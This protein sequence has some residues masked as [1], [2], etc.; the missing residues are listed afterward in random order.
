MAFGGRGAPVPLRVGH[1]PRASTAIAGVHEALR[2]HPGRAVPGSGRRWPSPT[3]GAARSG[4]PAT[5]CRRSA[6]TATRGLGWAG[7][8]VGDGV[9]TTN[10]AGRTLRDLILGRHSELTGLAWVGHRSRR[11]EPEPLRY[12]RDQ[13]RAPSGRS[14]PTPPSRGPV[15]PPGTPRPP[16]HAR[17]M[18]L[19][20]YAWRCAEPAASSSGDSAVSP[21]AASGREGGSTGPVVGGVLG[22]DPAVQ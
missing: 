18:S 6:S 15:G 3:A 11:W 20:W 12:P 9:S 16:P 7:G 10:L 5:G 4:S 1:P 22:E 17:R 2:R 19:H 8:Y 13:R 21:A 14:G